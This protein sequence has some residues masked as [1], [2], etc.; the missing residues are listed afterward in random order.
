MR[1]RSSPP[2]RPYR[3]DCRLL[4]CGQRAGVGQPRRRDPPLPRAEER[5]PRPLPAGRCTPRLP[6]A[7]PT[8]SGRLQAFPGDV[9]RAAAQPTR[10]RPSRVRYAS[11]PRTARAAHCR[12]TPRRPTNARAAPLHTPAPERSGS[13]PA[14][15]RPEPSAPTRRAGGHSSRCGGRRQGGTARSPSS[16]VVQSSQRRWKASTNAALA[17][18]LRSRAASCSRCAIASAR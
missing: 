2:S 16:P 13:R 14:P 11:P 3:G 5:S 17:S 18:V 7:H 6:H 4:Q 9:D 15:A 8:H 12:R 1:A 10:A